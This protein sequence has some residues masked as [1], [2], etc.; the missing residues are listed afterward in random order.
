MTCL[1]AISNN[2]SRRGVTPMAV[3]SCAGSQVSSEPVSTRQETGSVASSSFF[4]LTAVTLTR[5]KLITQSSLTRIRVN[6]IPQ[7]LARV[8]DLAGQ[9]ARRHR[10][11]RG[12]EHLRFLVAHAAGEIAV[13]RA[14]ALYAGLV[15]AA[16][17]VYRAAETRGAPGVFRHLHAGVHEDVPDGRVAPIR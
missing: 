1:F 13:R 15:D 14:D 11:R 12:E 10:H 17:R 7:I 6:S 3:S 16:K 5:N 9:G 8:G 2:R 4:G